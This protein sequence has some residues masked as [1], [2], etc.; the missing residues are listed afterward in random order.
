METKRD[1]ESALQKASHLLKYRARSVFEIR[2]RLLQKGFAEETIGRVVDLLI[3]ERLLD[4]EE[5]ASLWAEDRVRLRGLGPFALKR[6]LKQK[7]IAEEIIEETLD[8]IYQE[9]NPYELAQKL[10]EQKFAK[11]K[12]DEIDP[13]K[14]RNFLARRGHSFQVASEC[15]KAFLEKMREENQSRNSEWN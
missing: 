1:F 15:V 7:G 8:Q 3:E 14:L 9:Y 2:N 13:D 6:E 4:D 5:F 10:L 11:R 12:P